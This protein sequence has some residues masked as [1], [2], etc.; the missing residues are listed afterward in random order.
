M[1]QFKCPRCEDQV[2]EPNIPCPGCGLSFSQDILDDFEQ[3]ESL[4]KRALGKSHRKID[5]GEM[6][7]NI[8]KKMDW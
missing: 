1:Q 6:W 3:L 8:K 2:I 5:F 7:Q 4:L